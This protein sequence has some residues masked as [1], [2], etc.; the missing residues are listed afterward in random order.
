MKLQLLGPA[1]ALALAFSPAFA[2]ESAKGYAP[3]RPISECLDPARARSWHL[4]DS[5]ELLVN[6]GRKHFHLEL[7]PSCPELAFADSIAFRAGGGV[8]RIC[9]G[10]RDEVIALRRSP[11]VIPCRIARVTP[12]TKEDYKARMN[13]KEEAEGVVSVVD[14][15][16]G[17]APKTESKE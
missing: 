1:V 11:A 8:S 2:D 10:A 9:G 14:P 5:D 15:D 4:I 17:D 12:L 13:G 16:A 7:A 6:A 3:L